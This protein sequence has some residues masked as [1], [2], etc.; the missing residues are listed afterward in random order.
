MKK[1]PGWE[2]ALFKYLK[3]RHGKREVLLLP[4]ETQGQLIGWEDEQWLHF[5]LS[6]PR[7]SEREEFMWKDRTHL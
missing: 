5:L 2:R 6:P 1:S 4:R 3:G 7:A